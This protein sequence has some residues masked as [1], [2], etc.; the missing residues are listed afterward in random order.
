MK[1]AT[2]HGVM[3]V[4]FMAAGTVGCSQTP[5]AS[6]A[7]NTG[8]VARRVTVT[9]PPN[10]SQVDLRPVVAGTVDPACSL[11]RVVVHGPGPKA[12]FWVQPEPTV[13]DTGTW[14]A[15]V[16]IG[17]RVQRTGAVK[18]GGTYEV[19]AFANPTQPLKAGEELY[20]WPDAQARSGVLLV[21]RGSPA[22]GPP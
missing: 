14:E 19:V 12:R 18:D 21:E 6:S 8:C 5:A 10:R 16:Y 4:L 17:Q 1:S 2:I 20:Q 11:V 7:A 15:Q 9:S 3:S 13:S 22:S